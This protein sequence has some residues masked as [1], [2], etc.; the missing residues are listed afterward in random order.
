[1]NQLQDAESFKSIQGQCRRPHAAQ[2]CAD[3]MEVTSVV[4][5]D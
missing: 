5:K 4:S 3:H 1:M 2:T